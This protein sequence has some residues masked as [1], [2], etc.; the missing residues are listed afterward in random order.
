MGFLGLRGAGL[1]ASRGVAARLENSST[2]IT[3]A[4]YRK[5]VGRKRKTRFV[6]ARCMAQV[7]KRAWI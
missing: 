6:T 3:V 1:G 4:S 7:M 5:C 2:A